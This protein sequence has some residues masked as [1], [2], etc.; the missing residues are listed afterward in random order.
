VARSDDVRELAKQVLVDRR[1]DYLAGNHPDVPRQLYHGTVKDF[2]TFKRV[3][4]DQLG[5]HVGTRQ[6]S[7]EFAYD[8]GFEEGRGRGTAPNIMPVHVSLKNPLRL[9]D[10]GDW[11]HD[12]ILPQLV[13]QGKI[14]T[15]MERDLER[16]LDNMH[17]DDQREMMQKVIK[18]L[19]HDGVV[20]L[21]RNE[22]LSDR[23]N[24]KKA[25][26]GY[27]RDMGD[28]MFK[29]LYP[30]AQDSYILF[31]PG[32]IKSSIGNQGTYDPDNPNI[33]KAEGG[34]VED[35]QVLYHGPHEPMPNDLGIHVHSSPD[36]A[37][38]FMLT[39]QSEY[40]KFLMGRDQFIGGNHY[41][42]PDTVYH[43]TIH[44]IDAFDPRRIKRE[45]LGFH[46]GNQAQAHDFATGQRG[47]G[48]HDRD[49]GT[50]GKRPNIIPLHISLKNPLRMTDQGDWDH[51]K[52]LAAL[53]DEG[54]L[55]RDEWQQE[56]AKAD[57]RRRSD[58]YVASNA[59]MRDLLKQHGY[60]GVV[61]LNRSEGLS[62]GD[63]YRLGL[64][65]HSDYEDDADFQDAFPSASDSYIIF[66]PPQAKSA[67]SS[68]FDKQSPKLTRSTGGRLELARKVMGAKW[69]D[70]SPPHPSK[71]MPGVPRAV[72]AAGGAVIA[73]NGKPIADLAEKVKS[74]K[75]AGKNRNGVPEFDAVES[76]LPKA[77]YPYRLM[78]P[79]SQ[80]HAAQLMGLINGAHA[81]A[82]T[83]QVKIKD[84]VTDVDAIGRSKVLNP[85]RE[86]M[87]FVEKIGD[88]LHLRDGNHRVVN[89]MLRGE[90]TVEAK[91]ADMDGIIAP[92][93]SVK[94]YKLFNRK[95]DGQ[96]YPL[97]VG[98]NDPVAI[99]KWL[100]A[101]AGPEGKAPGKVKSKL[102]DLAY[103]PG[104]HAGDLP[105]ATHIGGNSTG[106][107]GAKPD[108][109]PDHQV[110]AEVEMADDVDWQSKAD[111]S[112]SRAITD[113]I[114]FGGHY[115]YKTNPNMTGNW[116]I[117]GQMKVNRILGDDE[118]KQI[119]DAAGVA[120]L[121]RLP[122]RAAG[123]E[124]PKATAGFS[125]GRTLREPDPAAVFTNDDHGAHPD[126]IH[127]VPDDPAQVTAKGKDP[128]W[129]H[130]IGDGVKLRSKWNDMDHEVTE[131]GLIL[132]RKLIKPTDFEIGS[133]LFP[134]IGDKTRAGG[135]LTH[136]NGIPLVRPQLLEGGA[137]FMRDNPGSIWASDKSIITKIANKVRGFGK[138]GPVYGIHV[139]M[140]PAGGDFAHMTA[141]PL[142]DWAMKSKKKI[143]DED[144]AAFDAALK[145]E[146]VKKGVDD[147]PGLKK[148]KDDWLQSTSGYN[149]S[150]LAK[151]MSSKRFQDAGFPDVA[152]LRKAVTEPGLLN[153]GLLTSGMTVGR[154]DPDGRVI[155]NPDRKHDTYN[156][157]LA[158]DYVGGL[159]YLPHDI[160]W[161]DV[162]D[163]RG[164]PP[165]MLQALFQYSKVHQKVTQEWIDRVM[166]YAEGLER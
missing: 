95:K 155:A 19:G 50:E 102:G 2:D 158:G 137:N 146:M 11:H 140:G 17:Y 117:G 24:L 16:R 4:E 116:L 86:G 108:H 31:D 59:A 112:K 62:P 21:N 75:P 104:W 76:P 5:F 30:S 60:D 58:G 53:Y 122:K 13:R 105:I 1:E 57:V 162:H 101:E 65:A 71:F 106:K 51:G 121:P 72:H 125:V 120:D 132:P 69:A 45:Q 114:P 48:P 44:D 138:E 127:G 9:S 54:K 126:A 67:L 94:A 165:Q 84:L 156:T 61:Y 100:L 77:E 139:A 66:D 163:E 74:L 29:S 55:T 88:R 89:A 79:R 82:E 49:Y 99:G 123:G 145:A 110:W 7:N 52:V 22:G 12:K 148:V 92:Q 90:D 68:G 26:L 134:L 157:H 80:A 119:N 34:A 115:R 103:R 43:G 14:T 124:I 164:L 131:S 83:Q 8:P 32:Q 70:G 20:Y 85:S 129:F 153:R 130:K 149:R 107:P 40:R 136:V 56:M 47:V 98:A 33:T 10:D 46:V 93:K 166:S 147:W 64:S 39:A 160:V 25:K 73:I 18:G 152:G 161:Q 41:E 35:D 3:K 96:I 91:V 42:I 28:N 133:T 159:G 6:A 78:A 154:F 97:F 37:H 142:L 27:R 143:K 87:P 141:R 81:G 36:Q 23:D 109:R 135:T 144:I 151:V 38:N 15:A 118:V 128:D 150:L 63:R 113:Q 111:A